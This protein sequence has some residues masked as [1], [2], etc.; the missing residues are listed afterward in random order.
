VISDSVGIQRVIKDHH[1]TAISSVEATGTIDEYAGRSAHICGAGLR[2]TA[3]E[4]VK[5]WFS[6]YAIRYA[7]RLKRSIEL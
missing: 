4:A 1:S 5:V 3:P 6:K 7:V 2:E